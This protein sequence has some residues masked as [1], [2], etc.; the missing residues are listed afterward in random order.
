MKTYLRL[1]PV[2]LLLCGVTAA[3]SAH[4]QQNARWN[5]ISPQ[6]L[7][8]QQV[9]LPVNG[10]QSPSVL[11][12]QLLLDHA[13]F[14]PGILDGRWGRNTAKAVR[15]FQQREG[16]NTTGT[17]NQP[18]LERLRQVA[19]NPTTLVEQH[20]LTAEDVDGPFVEIPEDIYAKAAM[21]CMCYESL[22]EKL[23]E[24]FHTSPALLRQLNPGVDLNRLQAGDEIMVLNVREDSAAVGAKVA[25]VVVADGGHY[26]HALDADGRILFHAPSTLGSDFA[27][28]P[29]GS[30]TVTGIAPRPT[31]HYQPD[32]L[33]GVDDSRKDAV[34]PP[35]PNNA[36]GLVWMDLSK[37]H[38]GIHGTSAP[39]T[40]GYATSHG[41]VRLTNWDALF[42]ADR[43]E[44]GTPVKFTR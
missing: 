19:G 11:Q 29:Q 34:I 9:R 30:F 1:L 26:L 31:W 4:A 41:C 27:P 13:L 38:Y 36:V 40:I 15:W 37:P 14:S 22:A 44:K 42:L 24:M 7:N 20:T 33:T 10:G 32:L 3:D 21:E 2:F 35:G 12:V 43:I 39:E 16:L 23:G 6:T 28:S 18:T 5:S 25:R 8:G 17:V